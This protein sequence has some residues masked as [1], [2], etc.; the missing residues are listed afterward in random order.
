MLDRK[1]LGL[2]L[3][4][5]SKVPCEMLYL[6]TGALELI[7]VIAVRRI[8]NLQSILRKDNREIIKKIYVAQQKSPCIGDWVLLVNEDRTKY[9]IENSDEKIAN[10]SDFEF[11]KHVKKQVRQH[12]FN[13]LKEIQTEHLKVKHINFDRLKLPQEYLCDKRFT[14]RLS[15]LLFN[16][17]C[18]SVNGV[19]GN[20]SNL[21]NGNTQC[22]FKCF[23]KEDTQEHMLE[24]HEL[25]TYLDQY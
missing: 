21:F 4:A 13:E 2:I 16:L 14:N 20:F 9:N 18:Q 22:Q 11:K 23:N 15:S 7:Y 3:G 8:I 1:I 10:M 6:E 12:A 5:Q 24:C 19:K 17:R 25:N